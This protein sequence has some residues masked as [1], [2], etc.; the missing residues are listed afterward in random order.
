MIN[1]TVL[2]LSDQAGKVIDHV[3]FKMLMKL[4][5]VGMTHAKAKKQDLKNEKK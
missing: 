4:E 3:L 2:L 1:V 5:S